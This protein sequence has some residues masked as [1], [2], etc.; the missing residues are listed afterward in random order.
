[1]SSADN[2]MPAGVSK[3]A[4][5]L[6]PSTLPDVELPANKATVSVDRVTI[7]IEQDSEKNIFEASD[8]YTAACGLFSWAL[9]AAPWLKP[10]VPAP[11][12]V[13][14]PF[15]AVLATHGTKSPQLQHSTV[16]PVVDVGQE[17]LGPTHHRLPPFLQADS[18]PQPN[19]TCELA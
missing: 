10:D 1:V 14:T 17:A 16:N 5:L 4:A 11:M 19:K 12:N 7:R 2:D 9:S 18:V 6:V 3:L 13:L 8:V 15:V